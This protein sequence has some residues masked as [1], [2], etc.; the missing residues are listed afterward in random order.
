MC[1]FG[2]KLASSVHY[3]RQSAQLLVSHEIM[4]CLGNSD[5]HHTC[6]DTIAGSSP[7]VGSIS[8]FTSQCT[9]SFVQAVLQTVPSFSR[10]IEAQLI[11]VRTDCPTETHEVLMSKEEL[12]GEDQDK[13]MKALLRLHK[14]F[15][16]PIDV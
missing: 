14:K 12:Q 7:D 16:T 13:I 9:P 2:L 4:T 15:G 5:P 10:D 11:E 6:H 8:Q 3:I 1:R